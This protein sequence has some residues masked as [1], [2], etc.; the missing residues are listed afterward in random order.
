MRLITNRTEYQFAEIVSSGHSA[1][2]ARAK[3]NVITDTL[4][5]Q[6]IWG[7]Q[8]YNTSFYSF[9]HGDPL[10]CATL[11]PLAAIPIS[12]GICVYT[13]RLLWCSGTYELQ[14]WL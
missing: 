14:N 13:W 5:S 9:V 10:K 7:H 12:D 11:M 4:F 2:H 8:W 3:K 1:Y 6:Y